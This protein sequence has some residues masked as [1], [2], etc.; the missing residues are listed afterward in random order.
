MDRL[1][2][3]TSAVYQICVQGILNQ[4]CRE[5][6]QALMIFT[7]YDQNGHPVTTLTGSLLDQAML[8][9]VLNTLYNFYQLPLLSVVCV[10][11]SYE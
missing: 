11:T 9:G 10:T 7:E 1:E 6:L 4:D 2:L 8:L 3:D 5:H